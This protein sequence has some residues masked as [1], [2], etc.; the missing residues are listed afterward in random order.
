MNISESVKKYLSHHVFQ[1]SRNHPVNL[2]QVQ[3]LPALQ[4]SSIKLENPFKI[5]LGLNFFSFSKSNFSLN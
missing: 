1:I 2:V 3:T 5:E 4:N